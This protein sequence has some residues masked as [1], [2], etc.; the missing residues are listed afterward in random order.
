M[1]VWQWLREY[2]ERITVIDPQPQFLQPG[3]AVDQ[4]AHVLQ[5]AVEGGHWML[6]P[7]RLITLVHAVQQ[8]IGRP[9]F[10]GLNVEHEVE[11]EGPNP[12]QTAPIAAARST[13]RLRSPRGENRR[14]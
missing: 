3:A 14:D 2:I 6:T 13:E 9:M 8:P 11:H 5:R 1:G 10:A 7:P 12:L 4:I